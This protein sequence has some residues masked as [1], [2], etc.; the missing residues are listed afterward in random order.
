MPSATTTIET[1]TPTPQT[2]GTEA[3]TTSLTSWMITMD[4]STMMG[5]ISEN[6]EY[7]EPKTFRNIFHLSCFHNYLSLLKYLIDF[8]CFHQ[9][10]NA[11]D[12]LNNCFKFDE[13][14]RLTSESKSKSRLVDHDCGVDFDN[15]TTKIEKNSVD[16][17][18]NENVVN[19]ISSYNS[20]KY[21]Q[22]NNNNNNSAGSSRNRYS[23]SSSTANGNNTTNNSNNSNNCVLIM[24][25]KRCKV[26]SNSNSKS[27]SNS[28]LIMYKKLIK[29]INE[30]DSNGM[31][32]LHI[33]IFYHYENEQNAL[34]LIKQLLKIKNII[35]INAP[36]THR[37]R[38]RRFRTIDRKWINYTAIELCD[39]Y[40]LMHCKNTLLG[41]SNNHG[42][43]TC[44]AGDGDG[45]SSY[46]GEQSTCD[47]NE[48]KLGGEDN[49]GGNGKNDNYIGSG[50]DDIN[51]INVNIIGDIGNKGIIIN[52]GEQSGYDNDDIH[53]S[54][55][56]AN[57]QVA[58]EQFS[59]N[60][61]KRRY[62]NYCKGS[63][64]APKLVD[65]DTWRDKYNGEYNSDSHVS[66]CN[67]DGST[68]EIDQN[69]KKSKNRSSSSDKSDRN[70]FNCDNANNGANGIKN[71]DN[72]AAQGETYMFEENNDNHSIDNVD[73]LLFE[74]LKV[75]KNMNVMFQ[76][77]FK[78]GELE[79]LEMVQ[80]PATNIDNV[81]VNA[82]E[83][84]NANEIERNTY[85]EINGN[86]FFVDIDKTTPNGI[87][88]FVNNN[89]NN[90]T[91]KDKISTQE[92]GNYEN[93]SIHGGVGIVGIIGD[94]SNYNN[95]FDL[96]KSTNLVCNYKQQQQPCRSMK[97]IKDTLNNSHQ[98]WK[99]KQQ[100]DSN[101]T[102]L[103]TNF[104][105]R[106]QSRYYNYSQ[107]GGGGGI[108][109]KSR[110]PTQKSSQKLEK[111]FKKRLG[112]NKDKSAKFEFEMW[113]TKLAG[114]KIDYVE[115]F[116][117]NNIADI[118]KLQRMKMKQIEKIVH[119]QCQA[120]RD[121]FWWKLMDLKQNTST[122]YR[123]LQRIM[124]KRT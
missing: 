28:N 50:R 45:G 83:N 29:M 123:E 86:Y 21:N 58:M 70:K 84:E 100:Y 23:N 120:D 20:T 46:N 19:N 71:G 87:T 5:I 75:D 57:N 27:K 85:V 51:A 59:Q 93:Q 106:K 72:S 121:H 91:K 7:I 90:N 18:Q 35:N 124:S 61:P 119:F 38:K 113:M 53:D 56:D 115:Q 62:D 79:G 63:K 107:V 30:I 82:N 34:K 12:N 74:Q 14:V 37:R 81:N 78:E 94:D 76:N 112:G 110:Q 15:H 47:E 109:T 32:P 118:K 69:T 41:V 10:E 88:S 77:E 97:K 117:E 36:I 102:E 48:T 9:Y 68:R 55:S 43:S 24:S 1:Q 22:K 66:Q 101:K 31:T 80:Q 11:R 108:R 54:D 26:N 16:E 6:I 52:H 60:L 13:S 17:K 122:I 103:S 92:T 2:A 25:G 3:T 105:N 99:E 116:D 49:I 98:E 64:D 73:H 111:K 114:M 4:T 89:N 39:E 8:I 40:G 65:C 44:L 96:T 33:S 42:N 104:H 67:Y 95:R